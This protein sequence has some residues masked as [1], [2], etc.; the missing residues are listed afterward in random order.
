MKG[1]RQPNRNARSMT[2]IELEMGALEL[3]L[4]STDS[5]MKALLAL[6]ERR[7]RLRHQLSELRAL[8]VNNQTR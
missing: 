5:T 3:E 4:R 6:S 2:S 7:E 1:R 8:I